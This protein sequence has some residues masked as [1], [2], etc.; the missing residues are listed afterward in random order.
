[1]SD[2]RVLGQRLLQESA[3]HMSPI[4]SFFK[5]L[6]TTL[7]T[8][9]TAT[10]T[11]APDTGFKLQT[12]AGHTVHRRASQTQT[13]VYATKTDIDSRLC[14]VP[15]GSPVREDLTEENMEDGRTPVVTGGDGENV[16][17]EADD[18]SHGEDEYNGDRSSVTDNIC[19]K[20]I[21]HCFPSLNRDKNGVV[22]HQNDNLFENMK[23]NGLNLLPR[24][25][26]AEKCRNKAT[27]SVVNVSNVDKRGA[28][29]LAVYRN[30]VSY[31]VLKSCRSKL[32][33]LAKSL[34]DKKTQN[35]Q[36]PRPSRK[37]AHDWE[38]IQNDG[39]SGNFGHHMFL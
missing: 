24:D 27:S 1:M 37:R 9:Q 36:H 18:S 4:T 34:F 6:T 32:R 16:Q 20:D 10:L 7:T 15:G 14:S 22:M 29:K 2:L 33:S 12:A 13:S 21:K 31:S 39:R 28:E 35:G 8:N 38:T 5:P 11:A 25:S 3:V 17:P 19:D 23:M 26:S 30:K